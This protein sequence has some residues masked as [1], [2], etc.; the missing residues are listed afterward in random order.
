LTAF[1]QIGLPAA[2]AP[3]PPAR[4]GWSSAWEAVGG[5]NATWTAA[6][7]GGLIALRLV[8]AALIPLYPNEAYYWTWSKHLAGGYY[9]HPP[10]VAVVIRLGTLIA[11]D[12]TLGVRI[13]GAL[14][15][16]PSTWAVWRAASVLF[17]DDRLGARAALYFNLTLMVWGS[18]IIITP[19]T[20]LIVATAFVVFFLA[21]L[22]E[23][24]RGYWWLAMGA[25]AGCG[26][27][28]KYTM[29]L[30][31]VAIL[32]WMIAVPQMRKWLATPWPY[33]A[34]LLS[35][36]LFVPTILWN[37]QHGYASL[38]KQFSRTK[39]EHF[40]PGF[41][42]DVIPAQIGMATPAVF[43]LAIAGLAALTRNRRSPADML[44]ITLICTLFGYFLWHSL[45]QGVHPNWFSPMYPAFAIA[46]A[47]GAEADRIPRA[48]GRTVAFCRRHA[49]GT[50]LALIGLISLQATIGLLPLGSR[51]PLSR[52]LA[53][54]WSELANEIEQIRARYHAAGVLATSYKLTS[55]LRFYLPPGV[56]VVDGGDEPM[57]WP[58]HSAAPGAGDAAGE[59]LLCVKPGGEQVETALG[60]TSVV[61]VAKLARMRRG[62]AIEHFEL[63]LVSGR[64][65]AASARTVVIP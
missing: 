22:V 17:A 12:T 40:T 59:P 18:F 43:V 33:L 14:L 60:Y 63:Y 44:L 62:A 53:F 21:K 64:K 15:A 25:A 2:G 8:L 13:F 48:L 47:M 36:L 9:D 37:A 5:G 16:I 42:F 23:T 51:D 35:M 4:S 24:G 11:G 41:F 45:H 6:F 10:M 52:K 34:G 20:P 28:A 39:A 54:G 19:D 46:A 61:P 1:T 32:I 38:I 57:R 31:G 29:F 30:V 49:I 3:A 50:A 26:L 27:L 58:Q 65:P 56:S 7:I 55:S